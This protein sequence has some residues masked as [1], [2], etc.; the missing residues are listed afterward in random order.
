MR[1]PLLGLL[2]WACLLAAFTPVAAAQDTADEHGPAGAD[3]GP[4]LEPGDAMPD[5]PL[6]TSLYDGE[7]GQARQPCPRSELA[8][9][10]SGLVVADFD[11]FYGNVVASAMLW[12]SHDL[13]GGGTEVFASLEAVRY[14]T[15]ISSVTADHVGPGHTSVGAT[16]RIYRA[17]ALSAGVTARLVLPTA[18]LLYDN[19]WPVGLDLGVAGLWVPLPRLRWSAE[20]G[21]MG[22]LAFGV[23]DPQPRLGLRLTT[24]ISYRLF[25][26]MSLLLQVEAG[27]GWAS[28]LDVLAPGLGLR[29]AFGPH[30]GLELGAVMPIAG[31]DRTLVAGVLRA[32]WRW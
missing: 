22:G 6:R 1:G 20:L 30:F 29:F 24:D 4:C 14:Q 19:A 17:D 32:A 15:V 26:A 2:A 9:G 13:D 21:L 12:W 31:T 16:R 11:N 18:F 28:T 3:R 7:L 10:G 23:G 25:E 8:L 5:G 27:M